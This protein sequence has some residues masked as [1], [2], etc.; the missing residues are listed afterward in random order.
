MPYKYSILIPVYNVEK[1]LREC[2]DSVLNQTYQNFEIIIIDDGSTDS[3]GDICDAYAKRD[4]RVKVYHQNNQGLIMARRNAIA[5]ATGDIYLFLDSDDYWDSDLL[6]IIDS[7]FSR[8]SCDMVIFNYKRV[9][10]NAITKQNAIF[11]DMQIFDNNNKH[12]LFE[13]IITSSSLNNLWLKAVR[14]AIVDSDNDYSGQ[15]IK[16]AED[17]LQ[18]LPLIY[19]AKIVYIDRALYNYRMNPESITNLPNV[20]EF[21]DISIVREKLLEYLKLLGYDTESN[22]R[23]FNIFYC[24]SMIGC[25]STIISSKL[26]KTK[27]MELLSEMHKIPLI[28]KA[29]NNVNYGDFSIKYIPALYLFKPLL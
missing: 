29:L 23:L 22:I 25:I 3:S 19:R 11:G 1:Y 7:V 21:I 4:A 24:T 6:Q 15:K 10:K 20:N 17:L 13:E 26:A 12:I 28:I 27:K 18:S 9:T 5:H 8:F 2:I 14:S 16:H